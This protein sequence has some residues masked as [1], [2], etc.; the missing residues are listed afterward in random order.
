MIKIGKKGELSKT[1]AFLDRT[2]AIAS[3]VLRASYI[4]EIQ[5][6]YD[7][8]FQFFIE[9]DDV[10]L[11]HN[12]AIRSSLSLFGS[13]IDRGDKARQIRFPEHKDFIAKWNQLFSDKYR[14][15]LKKADADG[16]L[17]KSITG[18]A[19]KTSRGSLS[20]DFIDTL[21]VFFGDATGFAERLK[22][23]NQ[24]MKIF[25]LPKEKFQ[26]LLKN[27]DIL[28]FMNRIFMMDYFVEFSKGFEYR[29]AGLI[30]E[31]FLA[32][33]VGGKVVGQRG[34][35]VDFQVGDSL[36][37]AKL[38]IGPLGAKQ[39]ISS[40]NKEGILG[41]KI[42]YVVGIKKVSEFNVEEKTISP[43]EIQ[44]IDIYN[45]DVTYKGNFK[46]V[47]DGESNP[48]LLWPDKKTVG[49]GKIIKAKTPVA[50]IKIMSTD[51]KG[52]K[53]YR[54]TLDAMLENKEDDTANLERQV[55]NKVKEI[56][57]NIKGGES[58]AR[59]YAQTGDL[60]KGQSA[61]KQLSS[62]REAITD[63]STFSEKYKLKAADTDT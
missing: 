48:D 16:S 40:F 29:E 45:F 9:K 8:I 49:F 46:F 61:M 12:K 20:R 63:L 26:N 17:G 59:S 52:I 28:D 7:E 27:V 60:E 55:L 37:S 5:K 33:L 19:I 23:F 57:D 11:Q 42:T 31:Y 39:A 15:I 32:G 62:S 22:I 2:G 3:E 25:N 4:K 41:K 38:V 30:F 10:I 51:K 54:Q 58:A 53:T 21:E 44:E 56:F 47:I 35:A 43:L 36:G 1:S 13:K 6:S 24:K 34:D 18:P 14:D 50:T